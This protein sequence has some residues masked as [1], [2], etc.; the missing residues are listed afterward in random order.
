[1]YRK[2]KVTVEI[3]GKEIEGI[4]YVMNRGQIAPPHHYYYNVIN[5]GY[6]DFKISTEALKRAYKE[7]RQDREL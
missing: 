5:Q 6:K 3:D 1:M 2:E 7:S 4:V